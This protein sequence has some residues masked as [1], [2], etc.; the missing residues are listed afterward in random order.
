MNI[1]DIAIIRLINQQIIKSKSIT[2]K[3]VVNSMGAMQAQDFLMS[4]WAVGIRQKNPSETAFDDAFNNGEILRTHLLRPTWHLVTSD[5]IYP[6]IDL[7]APQIKNRMKSRDKQLELTKSV[8]K[9]SNTLLEKALLEKKFI[10]RDEA[11]KIFEK[12]KIGLWDNRT[13]HLLMEAELDGI[14]CSGKIINGKPSYA[15][16]EQRVPVRKSIARDEV[17]SLLAKKYFTGHC[18]AAVEDFI[19]WSG[20]KPADAK[21]AVEM[22]RPDFVPEIIGN[23][24]YWFPNSFTMPRYE[25]GTVFFLPSYDEFLIG[26]RDRSASLQNEQSSRVVSSN[27]VFWPV[28]I[29][30]GSVIGRWKRETKK[31]KVIIETEL[32]S[33]ASKEMKHKLTE[34]AERYGKFREK[35]IEV[36]IK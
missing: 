26:Y 17:L 4:K 2:P 23:N 9:K 22:I 3:D 33:P 6:L 8:Y 25:K 10:T 21:A 5:D 18:P 35:E 24:T 14:I 16:L 30:D 32:F 28:I 36:I 7:T 15:L 19:W 20:L 11:V 1:D 27:G 12:A 13:A 31:D 29:K 34:A